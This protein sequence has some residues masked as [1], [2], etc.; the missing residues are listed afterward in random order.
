MI[1]PIYEGSSEFTGMPSFCIQSIDQNSRYLLKN[2][3]S[4]IFT[5]SDDITLLDQGVDF[6]ITSNVKV[7]ERTSYYSNELIDTDCKSLFIQWKDSFES[8][9]HI[10]TKKPFHILIQFKFDPSP[11]QVGQLHR[12]GIDCLFK[13]SSSS[14]PYC[15]SIYNVGDY[16]SFCLTSDR[17]DNLYSTI[18]SDLHGKT[19]GL[20]YSNAESINESIRLGEGVYYSRKRGLWHKG[21]SSG[22]TQ[23]LMKLSI[24]CDNDTLQFI[25]E[26]K[27][28]GFCHLDTFSCFGDDFGL[29]KLE[30]T[31]NA[32]LNDTVDGSYT[33]KLLN[34]KRLLD[35]KIKE[36]AAELTDA[37][38]PEDIAWEAADLI[39]FALVKCA[40]YGVTLLDI[41]KNLHIK[42]KKVTRRPG[43][44]K[45]VEA[46]H[47]LDIIGNEYKMQYHLFQSF[48]DDLY[49]KSL[50]RAT[51]P[52]VSDKVIPI[53]NAVK[54][55]GDAALIRLTMEFD[56]VYVDQTV[57]KAPFDEAFIEAVPK[58]TREAIDIAYNNIKKFHDA[59]LHNDIAVETMT[60]VFCSRTAVGIEKVGL[61]IPGGSAVL[62]S[63]A[64][65]LGVP[66]QSAKCSTIVFATPPCKSG[67]FQGKPSPEIVYVA[68]KVG[69]THILVSGGAQAISAL[70]YGTETCPKV[71]KIC[72]PGNQWVTAA[73]CIVQSD[74]S[75]C[76]SIDMPA[77]PS[78]LMVVC[79]TNAKMAFVASDLLSQA[80]HGA[81]S[82]VLC[83][84]IGLSDLN[85]KELIAEIE[86]QATVLPRS[87]TIKKSLLHSTLL[88]VQDEVTALKIANE[89]APE[90]LILQIDNC[91]EFSKLVKNAGSV[92][93]GPW[94]PESCGDYASGTNHTLPTH[95][96]A[97]M[98][99]GVSTNT[100]IKYITF[101]E[102]TKQGLETIG[103][104]VMTLANVEELKA[105]HNAVSIRLNK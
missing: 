99:G 103:P 46:P 26:Q 36:E 35:S 81:D 66:A 56:G 62:P 31:I 79:D 90:H 64:L 65:M 16:I 95:G 43:L 1:V 67:E 17:Q 61:Y 8:F 49:L 97:K 70:A 96:F 33:S 101:Q 29:T 13:I 37:Y 7:P 21:N 3:Y 14:M 94:T 77:G 52:D 50:K 6:L 22:N 40:K 4:K 48:S 39:Y 72:G 93:I 19:L 24:D 58:D 30:S 92:F 20:A 89:Y 68:K 28:T 55:D 60:G 74:L 73:K 9:L 63:T 2:L 105:H 85:V 42:S 75:A 27:G 91:N 76:V 78:E 38:T 100:F 59:Q 44:A 98:Y 57:L 45:P 47:Q 51:I 80:E 5:F 69:A 71:F 10:A 54:S 82:Q 12:L 88:I 87:S 15:K 53:I 84:G 32:R 104:T 41:E 23:V 102:I 25:V 83:I 34:N 86:E 11:T 18:V